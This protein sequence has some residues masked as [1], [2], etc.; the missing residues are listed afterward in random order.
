MRSIYLWVMDTD[1]AGDNAAYGAAFADV[2]DAWYEDVT[3][4]PATVDTLVRL[5]GGGNLLELGVGTGR[6]AIPIAERLAG[7]A[8]IV[9]VDASVEMLDVW[10][11]KLDRND[12]ARARSVV[13]HGDMRMPFVR[14]S[15]G[16]G[17][18]SVV[19]CTF[20]TFFNLPSHEAQRAC[21]ANAAA[22]LAPGGA[23]V[24]EFAVF[25]D[26][27][28]GAA[29]SETTETRTRRDGTTVTSTSRIDPGDHTASG[30]F[31][32]DSGRVRPWRIRWATPRM[33][34][35]MAAAAGLV[36]TDRW[37]DFTRMPFRDGSVRQVCV[38]RRR[39]AGT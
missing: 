29:P 18:F 33:I 12:T 15:F 21:L 1:L 36:C 22:A 8:R 27:D 13:V 19:F 2:Y 38:L 24:L 35:Q 4:V 37:E 11:A 39:L 26:V 7:R 6:I 5:A 9:G 30:S 17:P 28:S 25:H 20:N 34:D 23:V 14:E 32:D 16:H 31:T 10:R 3:D